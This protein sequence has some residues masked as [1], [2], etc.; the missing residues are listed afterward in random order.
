LQ[1]W[2]VTFTGDTDPGYYSNSS[3]NFTLYINSTLSNFIVRPNGEVYSLGSVLFIEG[4]VSDECENVSGAN[5][6]FNVYPSESQMTANNTNGGNYTA[7][8]VTSDQDAEWNNITMNS[9]KSYYYNGFYLKTD[10]F[11]VRNSP[12]LSAQAIDP[13][14]GEWGST[15]TSQV[16]IYDADNNDTVNIS[17]WKSVGGGPWTYVSSQTCHVEGGICLHQTK[18][19]VTPFNCSDLSGS[20]NLKFNSSDIYG[21][22]SETSNFS[23]NLDKDKIDFQIVQGNEAAT[24]GHGIKMR[25]DYSYYVS[26]NDLEITVNGPNASPIYAYQGY[27]NS[28]IARII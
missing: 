26:L 16:E 12:V 11:Q 18:Y 25:S 22:K 27:S 15:F 4:N 28:V 8:Y 7:S 1:W 19:F 10:A 14:S 17:L 21:L 5:V 24:W 6:I 9:S 2:N 13:S 20:V 23:V 3:Q